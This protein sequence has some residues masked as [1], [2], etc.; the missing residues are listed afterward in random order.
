MTSKVTTFGMAGV[1]TLAFERLPTC[2]DAQFLMPECTRHVPA[3]CDE[4][5]HPVPVHLALTAFTARGGRTGDHVD[6][7][8]IAVH[9]GRRSR[10]FIDNSRVQCR[11]LMPAGA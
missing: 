6:G 5:Q 10:V 1:G 11:A 9:E 8:G 7:W 4:Q 2:A 3:L